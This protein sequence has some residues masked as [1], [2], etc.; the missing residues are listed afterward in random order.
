M[1]TAQ[2]STGDLVYSA[3]G[4]DSLAI[5][6]HSTDLAQN[7]APPDHALRISGILQATLN[8]EQIFELFVREIKKVVSH[9]SVS[10]RN[11]LQ[12]VEL[13]HG[14]PARHS[15]TYQ[16]IVAGQPLGE[17]AFTRRKKFTA[18]E[19]LLIEHLLCGLVYPLR[20]ALMYKQAVEAAL[21]DPLTGV[22][23]RTAMDA[24][25]QREVDLAHRHGAPLSLIAVDIDHFK[26]VND[27]YGHTI[28]DSVLTTVAEATSASIRGTDMLFRYGGE[29]FV[30]LLSNTGREGALCLAE[31]IR[32]KVQMARYICNEAMI[33][34][35]I[36]LGVACLNT[37]ENATTLFTRADQALYQAKAAGRNCVKL[38]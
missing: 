9:D 14:K 2:Q 32:R 4:T 31:R 28:G 13:T 22:H 26:S 34:S 17:I 5:M 33:S 8:I 21:K 38:V 10:Y 24:I 3:F 30:V 16:L 7:P 27:T 37:G 19:S 20:N 18:Q 25:L 6:A 36:S 35:T 15:G 11:P 29:E 12:G 23:N 1:T